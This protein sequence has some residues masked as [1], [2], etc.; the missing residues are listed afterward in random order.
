MADIGSRQAVFL[1]GRD[2]LKDRFMVEPRRGDA[3]PVSVAIADH[4]GAAVRDLVSRVLHPADGVQNRDPNRHDLGFVLRWP[5]NDGERHIDHLEASF[6]IRRRE[7]HGQP[8]LLRAVPCKDDAE[9]NRQRAFEL[10]P[11]RK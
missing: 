11:G 3:R 6:H 7:I 8:G 1:A 4:H 2:C 5:Q 10:G 9:Q